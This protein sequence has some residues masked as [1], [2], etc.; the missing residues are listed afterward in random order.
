MF[1]TRVSDIFEK[2]IEPGYSIFMKFQSMGL[3]HSHIHY[4][5][6]EKICDQVHM[7]TSNWNI[8]ENKLKPLT[9]EKTNNCRK[10]FYFNF[11]DP[12][13]KNLAVIHNEK[14]KDK[15]VNTLKLRLLSGNIYE[16]IKTIKFSAERP[17][18]TINI[19]DLFETSE[20]K[21]GIIQIESSDY[22]FHASG[23]IINTKYN[24]IAVDHFTGG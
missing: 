24:T 16:K 3:S 1:K 12:N 13:Q 8:V 21:D 23:L 20:I 7:H 4:A 17:I 2:K 15:T 18:L 6:N 9:N 22:N 5:I 19:D 11:N 10:F 14:V